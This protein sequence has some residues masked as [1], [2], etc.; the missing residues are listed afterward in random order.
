MLERKSD[1]SN[2]LVSSDE[3]P[4]TS[5]E[6]ESFEYF[7]PMS[8]E[9][10]DALFADQVEKAQSRAKFEAFKKQS[11]GEV[12]TSLSPAA[13]TKIQF[14]KDLVLNE[15]LFSK[16]PTIAGPTVEGKEEFKSWKKVLPPFQEK[17]LTFLTFKD[18]R[19]FAMTDTA[20]HRMVYKI[21]YAKLFRTSWLQLSNVKEEIDFSIVFKAETDQIFEGYTA[22]QKSAPLTC[23]GP[24][25]STQKDSWVDV[26]GRNR[27]FLLN[28][29]LPQK[30]YTVNDFF[31]DSIEGFAR[32]ISQS[33]LDRI[34]NM[35]IADLPD[36]QDVTYCVKN[37]NATFSLLFLASWL[38]QIPILEILLEVAELEI[39]E[40]ASNPPLWIACLMGHQ[41][42]V[43][44]LLEK[45]ANP[46]TSRLDHS[47]LSI[48][49]RQG[50]FSVAQLLVEKKADINAFSW[51]ATPL[52]Y[53]LHHP[54]QQITEYLLASKAQLKKSYYPHELMLAVKSR[55]A[56]LVKLFLPNDN[57]CSFDDGGPV[58]WRATEQGDSE[59][60]K[61]LLANG[62]DPKA[63]FKSRDSISLAAKLGNL[64]LVKLFVEHEQKQSGKPYNGTITF[65]VAVWDKVSHEI[66][67]YLLRHT[68]ICF[69]D[70]V[71]HVFPLKDQL[72]MHIYEL[73]SS[74]SMYSFYMRELQ[75]N[76]LFLRH[77]LEKNEFE[78]N[79]PQIKTI[80]EKFPEG[81]TLRKLCGQV[82][83]L[84]D[85]PDRDRKA[86]PKVV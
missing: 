25:E 19:A 31:E 43:Q 63:I 57:I 1:S 17:V 50:H 21:F 27:V 4:T 42:G 68:R 66:L 33:A 18:L 34:F 69:A 23:M 38:N 84:A 74:Y 11:R 72:I 77:V 2:P 47:V 15:S 40:P 71:Y 54:N 81:S 55:N 85:S 46:N 51:G 56:D 83:D 49:A 14:Y 36:A 16:N 20:S 62:A 5:L 76:L 44:M 53:A 22:Y 9:M 60:V 28:G 67:S 80:M 39:N 58:V 8:G 35:A 64:D 30:D 6:L 37:T 59:I 29:D 52:T 65:T 73:L 86:E 82:V 3:V 13:T 26:Y 48:A 61:L 7:P 32:H 75:E 79:L 41:K 12:K 24:F 10:E 45:K 70:I 78:K